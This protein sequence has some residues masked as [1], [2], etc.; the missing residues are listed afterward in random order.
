MTLYQLETEGARILAM[1][2]VPEARLDARRLL[3]EAFGLDEA[4]YL[5]ERMQP[6]PKED[7]AWDTD[8]SIAVSPA[9]AEMP[10]AG[11]GADRR[12]GCTARYG[13]MIHRRAARIPLQQI[14]G[15]QEF[16]GLT[17]Q[18]DEHVLIPRQDTEALAELV[19]AEQSNPDRKLL[20]LCT[21]SGCIAVSLA[22]RGGYFDVTA[23]DLSAEALAVAERNARRLLGDGWRVETASPGSD[24]AIPASACRDDMTQGAGRLPEG[25]RRFRLCRGDLFEALPQ[26][27]RYDILVS[28]PPYIA[29]AEI[30]GLQ[31]EVRDH[32]P[33]MALD[34]AADGLTFYRRIAAEAPKRL[35]PGAS[36][37]LEIGWDQAE[38][39]RKLLS[40]A[41][42]THIEVFKDL[43]GLDRVVRAYGP[44]LNCSF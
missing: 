38:A 21:G 15:C 40:A 10:A 16:M 18:I 3:L 42:F 41:G 8:L 22:V 26:G 23:A 32:E 43:S 39:V 31:P 14:L 9:A 28:N 7:G 33:R 25:V 19:L 5:M 36:V 37:Y 1:A 35:N 17:F 6:L 44:L 2:G 12:D 34:G 20:D 30:D 11:E 24:A 4:R 27:N 13:E 29:S